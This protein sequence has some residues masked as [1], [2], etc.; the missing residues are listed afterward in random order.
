MLIE[1]SCDKFESCGKPRPPIVFRKG[2]NTVLGDSEGT[3]SIGKS[4]LLLIIDFAFGGTDYAKSDAVRH[5]STHTVNFKYEFDGK[6]YYF[7]R[8]TLT[9]D[10]VNICDESYNVIG[11][12]ITINKFNEMLYGLYNLDLPGMTFRNAVG[13]YIRVYGRENLLEKKPLLYVARESDENG[14]TA[15]IKLFGKYGRFE[16]LKALEKERIEKREAFKVA[17][18]FDFVPANITSKKKFDENVKQIAELKDELDTLTKQTDKKLSEEDLQQADIASEL[19]GKLA[20]AR[21]Q[22]TRLKS[23]LRAMEMNMEQ[24]VV[25][26]ECDLTDLLKFF[27]QTDV[28]AIGEIE[29]FHT[30]MKDVL[31]AEFEEEKQRIAGLI[32]SADV[33]IAALESKQSS[34]GVPAKLPKAFLDKYSELSGRIRGLENQNEA[35]DQSKE[36]KSDVDKVAAQLVDVEEQ[37]LRFLQNDINTKMANIND[38]IYNDKAHKPPILDLKSIKSYVFETP[39]DTGT[40]TSFKSL[41]VFDVTV[42]DLTPLPAL[43]HDSPILKNIGDAPVERIMELYAQSKKQVFISLDKGESYT[44]RT[45]EILNETAVI[46]LS[47]NG[48]QLFGRSWNIQQ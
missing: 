41:V 20:Y 38:F 15:L 29:N 25:L 24:G 34:L 33:E 42:L 4:T 27:P 39:D 1:I 19:K 3:N 5:I 30:K 32:E 37:E 17:M 13:R 40:G 36:L 22:R 31:A 21:R 28:K 46:H 18:K 35:Y 45:N 7:S 23:Q 44:K 47:G 9:H 6:P 14:I 16:E 26:T 48:N 11:T 2:L 8:S 10:R 12:P 43:V